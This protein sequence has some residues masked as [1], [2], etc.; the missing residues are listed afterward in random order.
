[1]PPTL[2]VK[3]KLVNIHNE[4]K[5][6]DSIIPISYILEWIAARRYKTGLEARVLVLES[7]TGSGK[8]TVFP[9]MLYERY[10]LSERINIAVT[11]PRTV[12]AVSIPRDQLV[13]S[14]HYPFLKLGIN[15]GYR[16]GNFRKKPLYGLTYMTIGSLLQE[17]RA[18]TD[19]ELMTIYK[20][21]IVDEVHDAS[22]DQAIFLY[23]LKNFADRNANNP[24]LPFI[25][26][27]SATL[28]PQK[29]LNYFNVPASS[30]IKVAG[31]TYP[32]ETRWLFDTAVA[33]ISR[34]VV[35]AC[36]TILKENDPDPNNRDI[37]VFLPGI[38]MIKDIAKLLKDEK[39]CLV[40]QITG[41]A[42]LK[43]TAD[44]QKLFVTTPQRKIILGTNMLE[45]GITLNNLKYVIDSGFTKSV[46][47]MAPYGAGGLI[48]VPET[49][50]SAKQR[51]GR[52]N[53]ISRG[54]YVPIF[55]QYVYDKLE[56]EAVPEILK[57]DLSN[58]ILTICDEYNKA[59]PPGE[60][61][62]ILK[63]NLLDQPPL[64]AYA[65][66]LEMLY[67]IGFLSPN[68][69]YDFNK[70][71]IGGGA[72]D[73][74]TTDSS[75]AQNF[76]EHL[77]QNF[78]MGGDYNLTRLGVL[79]AKIPILNPEQIRIILAAFSWDVS[80][81][82]MISI[83]A[84]LKLSNV[85]MAA[86]KRLPINWQ[87]IYA[88]GLPKYF[89][90]EYAIYRTRL[91]FGDNFID[92]AILAQAVINNLQ[93]D[94]AADIDIWADRVNIDREWLL[95]YLTLRDEIF[96][97]LIL[98]GVNVTFGAPS[99]LY[100]QLEESF[101]DMVVRIKYAIYDGYKCNI[102]EY[103][104]G[105][106]IT[107]NGGV[108]LIT[109]R[110]FADNEISKAELNKYGLKTIYTPA[111]IIYNNLFLKLNKLTQIYEV[112]ADLISVIEGYIYAC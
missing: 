32:L 29:L 50:A 66:C 27:M 105:A 102:A 20:Y 1:M 14:G 85:T 92:G 58:S 83:A 82:D 22:I 48:T 70:I 69:D 9:A 78:K 11:Q 53:R 87:S 108:K 97:V 74:N 76:S 109:P 81:G 55:P 86:D 110:L 43:N 72:P 40:L 12:N 15:I 5:D 80:I 99:S 17:F 111:R 84:Y 89:G 36:R 8:S 28:S 46:V 39:D 16:T 34:A 107:K 96:N 77:L 3:G 98:L 30:H 71:Y 47:Y 103:K 60:P 23:I 90:G 100:N 24:N 33:D 52:A 57:S 79:A 56:P 51:G 61:F 35:E 25:V 106:Y 18:R 49:Q 19:S 45:T 112:S 37:L 94:S 59:K 7:S 68:S 75:F 41:E 2:L 21:I 6:Y 65:K 42:Q 63:I 4:N 67:S 10:G 73:I 93:E 64:A 104:N 26:L 44:Y 54:V 13:A 95:E 88:A 31:F 38:A 91:M 62:D 101:L